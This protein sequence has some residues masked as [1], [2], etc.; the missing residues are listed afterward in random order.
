MPKTWHVTPSFVLVHALTGRWWA[1]WLVYEEEAKADKDTF[2]DWQARLALAYGGDGQ[3][4][5]LSRSNRLA[6]FRRWK[7][8]WIAPD[9]L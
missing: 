7:D 3:L 1:V 9:M 8:P 4:T 6:G 2:R 5:A